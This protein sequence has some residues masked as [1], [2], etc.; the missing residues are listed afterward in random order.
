MRPALVSLC[1]VVLFYVSNSMSL[2][3]ELSPASA[4]GV[5]LVGCIS[6]NREPIQVILPVSCF[7]EP[8]CPK[9]KITHNGFKGQKRK[10]VLT[11]RKCVHLFG[12]NTWAFL[13]QF[14]MQTEL[15][16]SIEGDT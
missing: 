15:L 2:A 11:L 10:A 13:F 12:N 16:Y 1:F 7:C 8:F 5:Y 9:E 3:P 14:S 4:A 6:L